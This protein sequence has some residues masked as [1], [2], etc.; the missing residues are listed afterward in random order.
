MGSRMRHGEGPPLIVVPLVPFV[1]GRPGVD[2]AEG[3]CAAGLRCHLGRWCGRWRPRGLMGPLK[4]PAFVGKS[5]SNGFF[6]D[7]SQGS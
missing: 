4:K 1:S 5:F 6:C 7:F 2:D 3:E